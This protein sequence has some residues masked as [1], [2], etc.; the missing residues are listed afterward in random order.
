MRALKISM[1][2]AICAAIVIPLGFFTFAADP[3]S[4]TQI[5]ASYGSTHTITSLDSAERK[6][7]DH[8]SRLDTELRD[9]LALTNQRRVIHQGL[10]GDT[11]GLR[12]LAV[13]LGTGLLAGKTP[14]IGLTAAFVNSILAHA[15]TSGSFGLDYDLFVLEIDK[16]A[17]ILENN[18]HIF[19]AYSD[20]DK[21][22]EAYEAW[23]IHTNG[24]DNPVPPKRNIGSLKSFQTYV[25]PRYL[26]CKAKCETVW[27][28]DRWGLTDLWGYN[29]YW[30]PKLPFHDL[31]VVP[32]S[33]MTSKATG[34]HLD[35]CAGCS[36]E[37]WSCKD[38]QVK[39]HE[40]LHCHKPIE[41]YG[42]DRLSGRW[43]WF[44]IKLCGETYRKCDDPKKKGVHRYNMK[45][46]SGT[47][48]YGR[49]GYYIKSYVPVQA[50]SQSTLSL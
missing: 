22:Y 5:T 16:Q 50:S 35:T 27:V 36:D 38:K 4:P 17:E 49:Q 33:E 30:S 42:Y 9:A 2:F 1:L 41:Y 40:V 14:Y 7:S 46:E 10:S 15:S 20:R 31:E 32:L 21:F 3:P 37:Y 13:S 12:S 29:D 45:R 6:Y 19:N 24:P 23:W 8:E 48:R 47:D 28:D 18:G 44:T 43:G 11:S 26:Q 34:D 39:D 25:P